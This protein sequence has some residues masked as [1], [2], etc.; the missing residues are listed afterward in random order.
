MG[1]EVWCC[2]LLVLPEQN[3]QGRGGLDREDLFIHGDSEGL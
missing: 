1:A 2:G 3:L